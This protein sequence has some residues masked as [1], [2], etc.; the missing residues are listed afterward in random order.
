VPHVTRT[1][2]GLVAELEEVF[3]TKVKKCLAIKVL[4]PLFV[5]QV[6]LSFQQ[7]KVAVIFVLVARHGDHKELGERVAVGVA[8][9]FFLQSR[10]SSYWPVLIGW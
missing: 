5:C 8:L 1:L 6:V 10:W 4:S 3:R 9:E 7:D 2:S